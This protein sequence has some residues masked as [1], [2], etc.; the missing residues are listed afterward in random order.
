MG[1]NS[2]IK[3]FFNSRMVVGY[4]IAF[5]MLFC[6]SGISASVHRYHEMRVPTTRGPETETPLRLK[7]P[8]H[9]DHDLRAKHLN[10]IIRHIGHQLLLQA[11]DFTSRVLPVTEVKQGTFQLRFEREFV[12]SHDSLMTLSQGLLPKTL[13]P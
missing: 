5:M 11:G 2:A 7:G 13:F 6:I 3:N 12:F 9:S 10:L 8:E 1:V 4:G